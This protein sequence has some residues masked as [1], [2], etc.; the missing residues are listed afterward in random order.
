L[1]VAVPLATESIVLRAVPFREADLVVTLFT[2]D[3]GKISGLARAARRSQRRFSGGLPLFT[4]GRA[5]LRERRGGELWTL[6]SFQV[7]RDFTGLARD[8]A[9][10]AHAS[11]GLELVRELTAAEQEDPAILDLLSELLETLTARGA[12]PSVLRAFELRLLAE[13]GVAP[14]ISR[15]VNC[16]SCEL[17]QPGTVLDSV[18]GGCVCVACAVPGRAVKPLPPAARQ[19]LLAAQTAGQLID[20][21]PDGALGADAARDALLATVLCHVGKPLRSVEFIAKVSGAVLRS[22]YENP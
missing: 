21:P 15:C 4:V 17:D 3:R 8:L 10:T 22:G 9:A 1:Y 2:R 20:A 7:L 11:Y 13:V 6:S 14:Q 18:R 19:L 16:G 12:S 5:E